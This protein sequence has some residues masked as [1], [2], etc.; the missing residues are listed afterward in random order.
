MAE[1]IYLTVSQEVNKIWTF[2]KKLWLNGL[3]LKL[4]S[5]LIVRK[6]SS[7]KDFYIEVKL[8]EDL[9]IIKILSKK[10]FMSLMIIPNLLLIITPNLERFAELMLIDQL[11]R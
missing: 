4:S 5:I 3:T 11:I 8:A 6:M 7:S 10:D 1:D 9:M 2:G